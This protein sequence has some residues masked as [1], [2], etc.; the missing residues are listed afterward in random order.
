ML[1]LH[2]LC[3]VCS[4]SFASCSL[5]FSLVSAVS[6]LTALASSMTLVFRCANTKTGLPET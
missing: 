2:S 4:L 1:A 5:A 3:W 6:A